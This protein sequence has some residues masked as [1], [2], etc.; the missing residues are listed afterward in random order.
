ML[1][2]AADPVVGPPGRVAAP[3]RTATGR[4]RAPLTPGAGP[5]DRPEEA[6]EAGGG[7]RPGG[8]TGGVDAGRTPC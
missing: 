2:V 8:R 1:A 3:R 7:D 5:G 6:R 4:A